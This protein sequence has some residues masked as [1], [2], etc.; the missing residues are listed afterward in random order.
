ML[1][2]SRNSPVVYPIGWQAL[3]LLVGCKRAEHSLQLSS[4]CA[5]ALTDSTVVC[6]QEGHWCSMSITMWC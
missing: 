5:C 6:Y 3:F 4:Y 1:L 2:R